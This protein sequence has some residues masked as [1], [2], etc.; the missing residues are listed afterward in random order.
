MAKVNRHNH[1]LMVN[2]RRESYHA[3]K[4]EGFVEGREYGKN[5]QMRVCNE[6]VENLTKF[7]K[8]IISGLEEKIKTMDKVIKG[9]DGS[10]FKLERVNAMRLIVTEENYMPN[11]SPSTVA[12][13][14]MTDGDGY[15]LFYRCDKPTLTAS[16]VVDV[17]N[18]VFEELLRREEVWLKEE[19]SQRR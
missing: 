1:P 7:Y 2:A 10:T 8:T 14:L 12:I 4:A 3:G 18:K 19:C 13:K 11:C 16:E 15:G 17:A 6:T 9:F 5:E